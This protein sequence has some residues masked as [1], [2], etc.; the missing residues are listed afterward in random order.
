MTNEQQEEVNK[1]Y[2]FAANLIVNENKSA[3]EAK[4]I[5]IS[6]G[7]NE[8]IA[9]IVVN[10][11]DEEIKIEKKEKAKKDMLHGALW[12]IGGIALTAITYSAASVNGG[13]YF[14]TWGAIIFGG[15]QFF[16]GVANS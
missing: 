10:N 5:L 15:I 6:N 4:K 13:S 14:I 9:E 11:L 2:N 16:K 7:F 8:E 3:N 1:A 12:C